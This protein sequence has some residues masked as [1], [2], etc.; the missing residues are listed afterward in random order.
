[1]VTLGCLALF[2]RAG[3]VAYFEPD[4][5]IHVAQVPGDVG[6][7]NQWGLDNTGQ[8]GGTPGADINAPAAWEITTG[9]PNIVV[10][11]LDE[12]VD[13]GEIIAQSKVE[14]EAGDNEAT[15]H[16]RIKIVERKL[17]VET[18]RELGDRL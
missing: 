17:I 7:A 6:F 14:I 15:L 13:T 12:G 3:S 4:A 8:N 16:E 5:V 2:S 10:A 11:V 1:M 9:N 18:L